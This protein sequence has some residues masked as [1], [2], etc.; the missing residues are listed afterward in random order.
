TSCGGI[1]SI[2]SEKRNGSRISSPGLCGSGEGMKSRLSRRRGR[3]WDPTSYV[4]TRAARPPPASGAGSLRF[5]Q[6]NFEL[7]L[8]FIADQDSAGFER[9][10]VGETKVAALDLGGRRCADSDI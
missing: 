8:D 3:G 4:R 7:N 9:R 6:R 2:E 1:S 10:V 5:D